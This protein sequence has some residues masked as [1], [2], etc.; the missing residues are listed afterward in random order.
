MSADSPTFGRSSGNRNGR[1]LTR[2]E[3]V[4]GLSVSVVVLL[5]LG[6]LAVVATPTRAEQPRIFGGTVF[7]RYWDGATGL[8]PAGFSAIDGEPV[9]RLGV[10][11]DDVFRPTRVRGG[12]SLP[13][14]TEQ[15]LLL[16]NRE[17]GAVRMIG[18]DLLTVGFEPVGSTTDSAR[19]NFAAAG[20]DRVYVLSP[21]GAS[22]DV[23]LH[24]VESLPL[25]EPAGALRLT[26]AE[27][28]PATLVSEVFP[29]GDYFQPLRASGG[30][31]QSL[32]TAVVGTDLYLATESGRLVRLGPP[33]T[34]ANDTET[35]DRDAQD[36]RD[37]FPLSIT[38]LGT[39][40]GDAVVVP[41]S[42]GNGIAAASLGASS[43]VLIRADGTQRQSNLL[44][45]GE[46]DRLL[47]APGGFGEWFVFR[48]ESGW[49]ARDARTQRSI[50][51]G[52]R[53]NDFSAA[54]V[55]GNGLVVADRS[56]GEV[57]SVNLASG[58]VETVLY[59]RNP[60][61]VADTVG[62]DIAFGALT[63]TGY[64]NRVV[65]DAAAL[66]QAILYGPEG[67]QPLAV[68]VK[69]AAP[70]LDPDSARDPRRTGDANEEPDPDDP[71]QTT[72]EN[73]PADIPCSDASEQQPNAVNL[74]SQDPSTRAP[75]TVLVQWDYELKS[76]SDCQ[77]AFIV[78][79]RA[80]G[81]DEITVAPDPAGQTSLVIGELKPNTTYRVQVTARIGP[82]ESISGA[83]DFLTA[84]QGPEPARNLRATE[85]D[86]GWQV[87][88]DG[89]CPA[90]SCL[91]R[92]TS[93][94][95]EVSAPS[96][97]YSEQLAPDETT[98]QLPYRPA[99]GSLP[100]DL[101]GLSVSIRL[102]AFS[103]TARTP[104]DIVS[105][106]GLVHYREPDLAQVLTSWSGGGAVSGSTR[107]RQVRL[108]LSVGDYRTVMGS[109]RPV[110]ATVRVSDLEGGT[111]SESV[112]WGPE[113]A[114]TSI[115]LVV[116]YRPDFGAPQLEINNGDQ[117]ATGPTPPLPSFDLVGCTVNVEL[118]P[119]S[120]TL[121][122]WEFTVASAS[123]NPCDAGVGDIA[124][125]NSCLPGTLTLAVTCRGANF[126]AGKSYGLSASLTPEASVRLAGNGYLPQVTLEVGEPS[127]PP[128]LALATVV[129]TVQWDGE[130]PAVVTAA[131]SEAVIGSDQSG[132]VIRDS[133]ILDQ[134]L[135]VSC[136]ANPCVLPTDGEP[137]VDLVTLSIRQQRGP[138]GA[139]PVGVTECT[140]GKGSQL[141]PA[142]ELRVNPDSTAC[143]LSRLV[144]MPLGEGN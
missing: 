140:L 44:F 25:G 72:P 13:F 76:Q 118:E 125:N 141:P 104:S 97:S 16:V 29:A 142:W 90:S 101:V 59:P 6:L 68:L 85:G 20:A 43:V 121:T 67:G 51:F 107:D 8:G 78:T 3:A 31:R 103:E 92:R 133:V 61:I 139:T 23:T 48:D 112:E 73:E 84:E 47:P 93:W 89:P 21:D 114:S 102:R 126:D 56:T 99:L 57:L 131:V 119:G 137:P 50:P 19:E 55:A 86:V 32:A 81:G 12:V 26:N 40:P 138:L 45:S 124:V 122:G 64:E 110:T 22:L 5:V 80:P 96:G 36:A 95:L 4:V 53:G 42:D 82:N 39:V 74:R 24:T 15:G 63:V 11:T 106:D 144:P 37:P 14:S 75:Q 41:A 113:S 71:V 134:A 132:P 62:N 69:S 87:T 105:L 7:V 100:T 18:P 35:S 34:E 135:R 54:A 123:G 136:D 83:E 28:N 66:S 117:S 108:D 1:R 127:P 2:A 9:A 58:A 94:I 52:E 128:A 98:F 38:E 17:N 88:W 27:L 143:V 65:V 46:A 91:V 115:P 120:P 129:V 70:P 79:A 10:R 116:P 109:T 111:W 33:D 77:P 60:E 49:F 30:V 130:N